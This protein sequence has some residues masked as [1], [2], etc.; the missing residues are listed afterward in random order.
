[1]LSE[2]VGWESPSPVVT[3][4][5][6]AIAWASIR[7]VD[8]VPRRGCDPAVSEIIQNTTP[9][10][11]NVAL[12]LDGDS[13]QRQRCVLPH[14]LVGLIDQAIPLRV[15]TTD[16]RANSLALGPVQ[17]VVRQ[18]ASWPFA[19]RRLATI[20]EN[21]AATPPTVLHALSHE[22]YAVTRA[23]A[24]EFDAE[25][26]WTVGGLADLE[27]ID[28]A[29]I[30]RVDA[31]VTHSQG[32]VERL[33]ERREVEPTRVHVIS[34]GVL[35]ASTPSAF[36][37]AARTP[38]IVCTASF[39]RTS[40]VAAVI[41][42]VDILRRRTR[43]AVL[44][45]LGEGSDESVL[46]RMVRD[47]R[48]APRVTFAH[49][50][51]DL[52]PAFMHADIFVRARRVQSFEDDLLQAMAAGLAVVCGPSEIDDCV[53]DGE[54][55]VL[56]DPGAPESI[57]DGFERLMSDIDDAR[58]IAERAQDHVRTRHTLSGM[59]ESA[60]RLYRDLTLRSTTFTVEGS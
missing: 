6:T 54:T 48:L 1:M 26:V 13:F 31:F 21:L 14:F 53:R 18:T 9:T 2:Y 39:E 25:L 38:T 42:A 33:R 32:M 5:S 11:A 50:S 51:G 27:A 57:A 22:S 3:R 28:Q 7:R 20:I 60:G 23:L 24:E 41:Q 56:C 52:T 47:L 19:G 30:A 4:A 35:A 36:V 46:R 44:F 55:A 34:P 37:D 10:G 59:A 17:V 40:F 29:D 8:M 15:V 49:P 12:F 16:P 45:L 43:S 58:A